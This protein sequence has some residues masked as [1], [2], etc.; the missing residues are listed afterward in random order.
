MAK[1]QKNQKKASEQTSTRA[2]KPKTGNQEVNQEKPSIGAFEIVEKYKKTFNIKPVGDSLPQDQVKLQRAIYAANA[3]LNVIFKNR[4][5]KYKDYL[6][7]LMEVAEAGLESPNIVHPQI[8]FDALEQIK[9]NIVLLEGRELKKKYLWDLLQKAIVLGS[10]VLAITLGLDYVWPEIFNFYPLGLVWAGA[11]TGVW[12]S[13]AIK[14]TK[15]SFEELPNYDERKI[16][17]FLHLIFAG[18]ITVV[19]ALFLKLEIIGITFNDIDFTEFPRHP[20]MS[21][22]LGFLGGFSEKALSLKILK[23]AQQAFGGEEK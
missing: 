23:K 7:A 1:P 10:G 15:M 6:K 13:V 21:F 5:E 2:K 22:V 18:I 14:R 4:E 16:V 17:P 12:V 11:M 8:A 9:T 19:F 20:E 3:I